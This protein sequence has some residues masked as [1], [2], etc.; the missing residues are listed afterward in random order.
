V[1]LVMLA[2]ELMDR[3]GDLVFVVVR[4]LVAVCVGL[5]LCVGV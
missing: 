1:V 3:V 4:L 5:R 2:V